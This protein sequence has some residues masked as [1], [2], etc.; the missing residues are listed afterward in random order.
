VITG[1]ID[2]ELLVLPSGGPLHPWWWS[3]PPGVPAHTITVGSAGMGEDD[4]VGRAEEWGVL[5]R[6]LDE[7]P[8]SS[9]VLIEGEPGIGK[10]MLLDRAA[11]YAASSDVRVFRCNGD[12]LAISQP[13]HAFKGELAPAAELFARGLEPF[14]E[15]SGGARDVPALLLIDDLQWADPATLDILVPLVRD[16]VHAGGTVFAAFRPAAD[17]VDLQRTL[18]RLHRLDPTHL[19]LGAMADAELLA[20]AAAELAGQPGPGLRA[21]VRKTGGNPLFVS[22]LVAGL[23]SEGKLIA[24]NGVVDVDGQQ[25]VG[26]FRQ[27]ALRRVRM[28]GNDAWALLRSASVLGR[29]LR[30]PLVTGLTDLPAARV[31]ALISDAAAAGLLLAEGDDDIVFR[32][33]LIRE[34]LYEELLPSI[35]QQ[36][37]RRVI[38]LLQ[39]TGSPSAELVPHLLRVDLAPDDVDL[40]MACAPLG[41]PQ[42]ASMLLERATAVARSEPE[43]RLLAI[44]Q[45]ETLVWCGDLERAIVEVGRL[46]DEQLPDAEKVRLKL[47]RLRAVHHA[48]RAQDA[49]H[50]FEQLPSEAD[51]ALRGAEAA[52][53]AIGYSSA[54]RTA[55]SRRAADLAIRLT[56][57]P[58]AIVAARLGLAWS[59]LAQ[60]R[61]DE[62]HE[63]VDTALRVIADNGVT[64]QYG[65]HL[66]AAFIARDAGHHDA[67]LRWAEQDANNHTD[68]TTLMRIGHRH[69][70]TALVDIDEGRWDQARASLDA[71]I[72]HCLDFGLR[73]TMAWL[74]SVRELLDLFRDGP[75]ARRDPLE[76]PTQTDL[77]S[78]WSL[79]RDAVSAELGGDPTEARRVLLAILEPDSGFGDRPALVVCGPRLARLAIEGRRP[80]QAQK[81]LRALTSLPPGQDDPSAHLATRWVEGLLRHDTN[82]L[83]LMAESF[84]ESRPLAAALL[85]DDAARVEAMTGTAA[86]ARDLGKRAVQ[87]HQRLGAS[88]LERAL[89][90]RLAELA[91]ALR[92]PA[93]PKRPSYGWASLTPAEEGVLALLATGRS[94]VE[95]AAELSVSRRTVESHLSHVY[96]KLDVSSRMELAIQLIARS[97]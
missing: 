40:V 60:G 20:L 84:E 1:L 97:R 29:S 94:N 49:V 17:S 39:A 24:R 28:L 71:G 44:R 41:T 25:I 83:A 36:L 26:S 64:R 16:L 56:D 79:L 66:T 50:D 65:P 2:V 54:R 72:V 27:L 59:S 45:V 32:H 73:P 34:A 62:A 87:T 19:E 15:I 75:T 55:Q 58:D 80:D 3:A 69:L 46:L 12:D 14:T 92:V 10:T 78:H 11:R 21:M 57:D 38:E 47:T 6:A 86:R 37:H 63:Q 95:I 31:S 82:G 68:V 52:E 90:E 30:L 48:G 18:D 91:V 67:A 96:R 53:L 13:Y 89:R 85:L 77:G 76:P 33:D 70:L 35:R 8:R 61:I 5:Q 23:R 42:A 22:T 9:V 93:A 43:R 88:G 4:F 7:L 51:P 74:I 81:V